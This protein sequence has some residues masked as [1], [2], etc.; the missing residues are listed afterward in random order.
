MNNELQD[1]K[2]VDF[3]RQLNETLEFVIQRIAFVDTNL[4]I[5]N[6]EVMKVMS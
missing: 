6:S 3:N 2:M 4:K 5:S 1:S